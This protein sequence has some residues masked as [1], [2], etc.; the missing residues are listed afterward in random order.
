MV[1]HRSSQPPGFKR[2]G[3]MFVLS[4]PSGAGKS[5]I[6]NRLL[7]EEAGKLKMSVSYTTRPMRPG[8]EEGRD[9]HFVDTE[10]FRAM[11]EDDAFLEWARVFDQR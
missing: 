8:E 2:R 11:V 4:S 9:Y 3:L 1:D 7:Q 10:Q 5:T 6:A